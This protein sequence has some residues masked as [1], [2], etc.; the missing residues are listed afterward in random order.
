MIRSCLCSRNFDSHCS[1]AETK[2]YEDV[3][4]YLTSTKELL[5]GT[6]P[7]NNVEL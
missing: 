5:Q 7:S 6:N 1:K 2:V 3:A 4:K